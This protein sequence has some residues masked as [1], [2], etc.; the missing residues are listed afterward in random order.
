M[1]YE[2][3]L[4]IAKK[5]NIAL[6]EWHLNNDHYYFMRKIY[7]AFV[8]QCL[9]LGKDDFLITF[10]KNDIR[11]FS[12]NIATW[13]NYFSDC[14]Y[15]FFLKHFA[16]ESYRYRITHFP[17]CLLDIRAYNLIYYGVCKPDSTKVNYGPEEVSMKYYL[18]TF[19]SLEIKNKYLLPLKKKYV[20]G[21]I[22][23]EKVA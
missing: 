3:K 2:Q 9:F 22:E 23:N 10:S 5:L 8:F 12:K 14:L 18:E 13:I 17:H 4:D 6:R 7:F 20:I 15:L 16:T 11:S 19:F 21:A 1:T